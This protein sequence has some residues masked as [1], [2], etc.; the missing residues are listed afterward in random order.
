M[1]LI[2]ID[3]SLETHVS[4]M[5]GTRVCLFTFFFNFIILIYLKAHL[6]LF[7]YLKY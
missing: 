6:Y 3:E 2:S 5:K 1:E 7:I 4:H